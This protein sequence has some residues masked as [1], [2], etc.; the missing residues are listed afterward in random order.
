MGRRGRRRKQPLDDL[1]EKIRHWKSKDEAL[2]HTFLRTRFGR[3]Q[4]PDVGQPAV[5]GSHFE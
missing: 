1:R 3:G 2:Y 4:G 5:L